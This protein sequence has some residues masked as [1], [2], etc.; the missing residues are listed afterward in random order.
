MRSFL[1]R[2]L[3]RVRLF[4]PAVAVV[5]VGLVEVAGRRW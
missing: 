1:A 2:G 3:D 4:L 5:A